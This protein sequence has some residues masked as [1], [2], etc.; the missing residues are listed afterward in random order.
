MA[1]IEWIP[2]D[3]QPRGSG[4]DR[5]RSATAKGSTLSARPCAMNTGKPRRRDM[6]R[7]HDASSTIVPESKTRPLSGL[8]NETPLHSRPS[9]LESIRRARWARREIDRVCRADPRRAMRRP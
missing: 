6:F 8:S 2:C 4:F 5:S 3:F 1:A 9:R 7:S